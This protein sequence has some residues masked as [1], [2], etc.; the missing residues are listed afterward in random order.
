MDYII[1]LCN[2]NLGVCFQIFFA[3]SYYCIFKRHTGRPTHKTGKTTR[4]QGTDRRIRG[5]WLTG[6]V[7]L[8]RPKFSEH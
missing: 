3:L 1:L 8:L 4:N 2:H 7:T 6:L 5:Q